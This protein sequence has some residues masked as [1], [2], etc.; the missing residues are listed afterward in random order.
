MAA[1]YDR[2]AP[3]YDQT[4]PAIYTHFGRLLVE[5]ADLAAGQRALDIATG[6]G[7]CLGPAQESVGPKGKVTGIDLST[8]ML[9]AQEPGAPPRPALARMDAE[10]LAFADASFDAITCA[11]SLPLF[12]DPRRALIAAKQALVPGGRLALSLWQEDFG[13][14]AWL[15]SWFRSSSKFP[16]ASP[17]R[18]PIAQDSATVGFQKELGRA[19][20][21]EIRVTSEEATFS[22]SSP[23][24]WWASLWSHGFR[25]RLEKLK[26]FFLYQLKNKGLEAIRQLQGPSGIPISLRASMIVGR[27]GEATRPR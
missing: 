19:G 1:I 4:G 7:A 3:L 14:F 11:F 12:P 21:D 22:Y 18:D 25:E 8:A 17:A 23:A 24:Q 13:Y 20:F 6:R 26:P 2:A 27:N 9:L 16:A 5:K 15:D 10:N